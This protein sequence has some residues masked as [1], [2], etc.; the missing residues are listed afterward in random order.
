[1][2][3]ITPLTPITPMAPLER[4][5]PDAASRS[6]DVVRSVAVQVL[7]MRPAARD[8]ITFTLAL[9][10]TRLA[11]AAYQPGQFI[12]LTIPAASGSVLYRS[13]S[14]CGDG[15]AEMPWEITV[16][17][18]PGGAISTYL[19][20]QI[21]PGMLLRTSLPKGTFTLPATLGANALV[22]LV[23]GGSGITPIYSLLR[24]IAR[25][26]AA[27]RPR[28]LLHY[29]Y[30]SPADAIFGREL[31][32]LDPDGRWLTQHHYVTTS[33]ERFT[34]T[35]ALASAG[36]RVAA[37]EWYVCGPAMLK[38]DLEAEAARQGV[39]A[40]R[41][42][43][44]VFASPAVRS[45]R[46]TATAASS[47]RVRLAESGTV[48]ES[49]AGETLL[50]ALERNG[51]RPDFSCRAG[52]CG[53]CKLRLL[54]GQVC[55]GGGD[56]G[57][58]TDDERARG[59]IL[60]C[61]AQPQGDVT[62]ASAGPRVAAPRSS[63]AGTNNVRRLDRARAT[64]TL[65]VSIAAAALGVFVTAWSFTNHTPLTQ[66]QTSTTSSSTSTNGTSSST[67]SSSSSNGWSSI[68]TQPSQSVPNTSTGVS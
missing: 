13:Y 3:A 43:A 31:R 19:L 46:R 63:T 30:H 40:A 65:R 6:G 44:E 37:A 58:L 54:A 10:R 2:T 57:A 5:E 28:V 20:D 12:T 50:E 4:R 42:H 22:V 23:A 24:G 45:A 35:R 55:N 16:K 8:T 17:R 9:P 66:A 1:M 27:A 62:L 32:A 56:S 7:G 61:V 38:R 48:I 34:A 39:P 18:T 60:S 67:G 25:L 26:D 47:A 59:Y 41:L 14:L 36:S 29:A 33:G 68:T 51:Y 21:R 49:Q 53:T 52:A 64:R 11:P 15:R